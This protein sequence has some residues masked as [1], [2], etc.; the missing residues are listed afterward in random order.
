M[1]SLLVVMATSGAPRKWWRVLREIAK[2]EHVYQKLSSD[3]PL[4]MHGLYGML[5]DL[6]D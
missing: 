3:W 6:I 5:V 1:L 4:A 2:F